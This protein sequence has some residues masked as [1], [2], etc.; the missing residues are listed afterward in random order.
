MSSKHKESKTEQKLNE[1]IDQSSQRYQD[2]IEHEK[3]EFA[4]LEAIIRKLDRCI[5]QF[6]PAAVITPDVDSGKNP[7]PF[8]VVT[9]GLPEQ[10]TTAEEDRRW[11]IYEK[12]MTRSQRAAYE[13]AKTRNFGELGA[14]QS[15]GFTFLSKS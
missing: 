9:P 1:F 11:A 14:R 7:P 10:A 3:K 6:T 15:A 2:R 8:S 12:K 5:T 4:L 13:D